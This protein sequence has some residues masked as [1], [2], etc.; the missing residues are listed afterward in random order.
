MQLTLHSEYALRVLLFAGAHPDRV[1]ST[2]E[3]SGA[4]GI[5]KNHLVRVV[6]TLNEHG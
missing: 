6:Q 5:S 3:I 1:C 2:R 4:Y